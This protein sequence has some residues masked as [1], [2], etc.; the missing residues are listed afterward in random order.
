[1]AVKFAELAA[2]PGEITFEDYLK[3]PEMMERHEIIEGVLNMSPAPSDDHQ[4]DLSELN[5]RVKSYVRSNDLG[6]VLFAPMDVT[7]RKL[8]KLNTRQPDLAFFSWATLG[9]KGREALR[10]ARE[11]GVAPDLVVE[12]LSPE[13]TKRYLDLKLTDY[14]SIGIPETWLANREAM[15]VEVMRL[16]SGVYVRTGLYGRGTRIVSQALPGLAITIDDIFAS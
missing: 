5:D 6:I 15:T 7:I 4:L 12:I 11:R 8:P 16:Q 9:G 3:M 2:D 1:M 13:E 14:A 10:E